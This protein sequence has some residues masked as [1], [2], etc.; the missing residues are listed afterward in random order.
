MPM[1]RMYYEPKAPPCELGCLFTK[2]CAAN[3]TACDE[4]NRYLYTDKLIDPPKEN[5]FEHQTDSNK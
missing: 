5:P 2:Q 3:G 4:F 1:T